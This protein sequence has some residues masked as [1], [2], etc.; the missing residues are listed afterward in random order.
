MKDLVNKLDHVALQVD[1][2]SDAVEW[3]KNTI[4]AEVIYHDVT[5]ALIKIFDVKVA[6]VRPEDHPTHIAFQSDNLEGIKDHLNM[7]KIGKHRDDSEYIYLKDP[8]GNAIEWVR[9]PNKNRSEKL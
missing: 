3:Y 9:Y 5:W 4:D 6:L 8:F 1:S 7:S 2:I